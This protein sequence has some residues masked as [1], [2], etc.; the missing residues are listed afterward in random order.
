[1]G[2]ERHFNEQSKFNLLLRSSDSYQENLNGD[3]LFP[4]HDENKNLRVF[5]NRMDIFLLAVH[6]FSYSQK[7]VNL[8]FVSTRRSSL[9]VSTKSWA[10]Q[11]ATEVFYFL[12]M[13]AASKASK[14]R[15][16]LVKRAV[17]SSTIT[18]LKVVDAIFHSVVNRRPRETCQLYGER[19]SN[20]W[21]F[22]WGLL[23]YSNMGKRWLGEIIFV[24]V[25]I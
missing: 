25:L 5:L 11:E 3:I 20:F 13:T 8:L 15:K 22:E 24:N 14:Y 6:L 2:N 23:K 18:W 21:S 4:S 9:A 16:K 19:E 17:A 12:E 7:I 10:M 1:M